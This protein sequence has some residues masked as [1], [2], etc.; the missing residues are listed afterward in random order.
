M[1]R[2]SPPPGAAAAARGLLLL[3][4]V[5]GTATLVASQ[6]LH[7]AAAEGDLDRVT[8]LLER[9]NVDVNQPNKGTWSVSRGLWLLFRDAPLLCSLIRAGRLVTQMA[10]A[11]Y[12]KRQ[13]ATTRTY[14]RH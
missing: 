5:A 7:D 9:P 6:P 10:G 13:L 14:A 3:L 8:V 1:H 2:R 11:R 12:R 4:L